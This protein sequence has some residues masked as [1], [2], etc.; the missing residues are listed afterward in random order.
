[1]QL[2]KFREPLMKILVVTNLY[3][4]Q[5]LGGYGRSIHDFATVLT[6]RGHDI[7]VLCGNLL[8]WQ[9]GVVS[10]P[11]VSRSLQ[12]YGRW[13]DGGVKFFDDREQIRR[14]IK[15]NH[16]CIAAA[17]DR[18]RPNVCLIGNI[19]LISPSPFEVLISK[20][21]PVLH[22]LGNSSPSFPPSMTPS[23]PL[24]RLCAASYWLKDYLMHKGYPIRNA[25]VVYPGAFVRQFHSQEL[26][27]RD[28][29]RIAYAGLVMPYKG[30]DLLIQALEVLHARQVSFTCSIA[31]DTIDPT[32]V[33][34]LKDQ[35]VRHG[36][37]E[38]VSF[39]G[40]LPRERLI[41]LYRVHN[42][43]AFPT[44]INE[45]FGISQ[46]EALAAG[47]V[48]VS[49]GNG[50]AAEVIEHGTSGLIFE[51][52]NAAALADAFL[53]LH[54]DPQRWEKLA[55]NGQQCAIEQ[56]DIERSVD[57]LELELTQLGTIASPS[58]MHLPV[59]GDCP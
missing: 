48:C 3:P 49:S 14:A 59:N 12:L 47:L 39:L 5:E 1:M 58:V 35:V 26:P 7:H 15:F 46:V 54:R 31:G 42:V 2:A 13:Q 57:Q 44:I 33:E 23:S 32:Y 51:S 18:F 20:S 38:K 10:E 17:V 4:P 25:S 16:M 6:G 55:R 53:V 43:L 56:F 28:H 22:H 52:G 9:R 24:Y 50:G 40:Y 11:Q 41:E 19:D 29:L 34:G 36:F 30:A 37:A 27:Q 21:V 45:T 8:E